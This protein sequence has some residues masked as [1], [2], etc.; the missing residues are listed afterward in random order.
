MIMRLTFSLR[1]SVHFIAASSLVIPTLAPLASQLTQPIHS[2]SQSL[3]HSQVEQRYGRLPLSFEANM[4][5]TDSQVKF[6][7]RGRGYTLFLTPT[8]AVFQLRNAECGMRNERGNKLSFRNPQSAIRNPQS[9]ALR[10]RLVGA[11]HQPQMVGLEE[12]PGK[13]NYFIGKDPGKW[14]TDI[15]AYAKVKYE[16]VYPGVDVV[17]YGN[18]G[19][20]EYDF[21]VAPGADPN[22]IM[23]E[24]DGAEEVAVDSGGDLVIHAGDV[25]IRQRNPRTYQDLN[26]QRVE[27]GRAYAIHESRFT[28]HDCEFRCGQLRSGQV[29][30]RRPG[31]GLFHLSGW[32]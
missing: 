32:K 30:D 16:S 27:V 9:V 22:R 7:A 28:N 18:Q 5:Q 25:E 3:P 14:H 21:I 2:D 23:L 11:T 29:P 8:E 26:G 13:V 6:L 17:Y 15:P 4:G 10:M 1:G 19:Q 12:L 20:L 24:F 31:V